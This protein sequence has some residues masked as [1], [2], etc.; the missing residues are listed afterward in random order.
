MSNHIFVVKFVSVGFF[1]KV[2]VIFDLF[3]Y[4]S[5][6]VNVKVSSDTEKFHRYW[7]MPY[8]SQLHYMQLCI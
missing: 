7:K 8:T 5:Q 3:A 4:V 1:N 2:W 6:F